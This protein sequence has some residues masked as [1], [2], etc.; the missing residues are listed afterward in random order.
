MDKSTHHSYIFVT[1]LFFSFFFLEPGQAAFSNYN[2]IL[3]GDLA[4]G[5]GGAAAAVPGDT[6][7]A[8]FYNPATLS[9]IKG[10]TFSASVGIYKKFDTTF[11]QDEDFTKAP[12]RVNQGF[13]RSVPSSVGQLQRFG[14]YVFA[15]SIVVPDYDEFKGDL[16]KQDQNA[17]T[18]SFRDESLWVGGAI[19]RK[20]SETESLGVTVYYT[21]RTFDRSLNDRTYTGTTQATLYT[22][23]KTLKQ[24]TIATVVGYYKQVNAK[25]ALGLSTRLPTFKIAGSAVLFKSLTQVNTA[26]STLTS[27]TDNYP[28]QK[29]RAVVPGNIRLGASYRANEIWLWAADVTVNQAVSYLDIE[30]DAIATQTDHISI[31]NVNLGCQTK[32]RDWLHTRVGIFSNLSSHR[33]PNPNK[34]EYQD[35]KVDM[36][37]FSANFVIISDGKLEFTFGGYYTGGKGR[38]MQRVQQNYSVVPKNQ[39]VFTML[40][41]SSYYF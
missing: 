32:W 31:W 11:G 4:A 1:A 5:M 22:E 38:S 14:D 2:S 29:A 41:G 37:G 7:A 20:I 12:L 16:K 26:T 24:N 10:D 33:D 34:L 40:V 39:H 9:E 13:F 19:A 18:L 35:D 17:T 8:A 6:S 36:L 21:A 27:T 15:L 30:N 23:E 28:D 3:I 25:W